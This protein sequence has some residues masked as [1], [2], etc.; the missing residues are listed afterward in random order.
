VPIEDT[1]GAL[2]ELVT[3]GK[4][5]WL[6]MCEA[7]AETVRRAHAVHPVTAVQTELSMFSRDP[8][9]GLLQT[10]D[11]LGIGFMAYAPLSRGLLSGRITA[12]SDLTADD[13]RLGLPRFATGAIDHNTGLARRLGELAARRGLTLAQLAIGW[14]LAQGTHVVPLCGTKRRTHLRENVAA[15]TVTLT[16]ADLAEVDTLF[17]A[18]GVVGDRYPDM[19]HVDV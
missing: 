12:R 8:C 16:A 2:G 14:V 17:A 9:N 4:V 15:A 5:R 13:W 18:A 7:R 19:S 1:W 6:G 3:A 11:E 10:L